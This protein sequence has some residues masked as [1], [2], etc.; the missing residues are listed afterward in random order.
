MRVYVGKYP[1]HTICMQDILPK[2]ILY[3]HVVCTYI[4][5]SWAIQSEGLRCKMFLNE[6][7]INQGIIHINMINTI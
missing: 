1:Y 4:T 7:I 6:S 5:L 3:M 2:I